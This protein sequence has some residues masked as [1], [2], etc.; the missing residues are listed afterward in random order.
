M[1]ATAKNQGPFVTVVLRRLSLSNKSVCH[2]KAE[3]IALRPIYIALCGAPALLTKHHSNHCSIHASVCRK[4]DLCGS[5]TVEV[6]YYLFTCLLHTTPFR[7]TSESN[8]PNTCFKILAG[9]EYHTS[10]SEH[11]WKHMYCEQYCL[12][13]KRVMRLRVCEE[14]SYEFPFLHVGAVAADAGI[15]RTSILII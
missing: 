14:S 8:V 7:S 6:A 9:S 1:R 5:S 13:R 15:Q 10:S 4:R 2:R 11:G 12:T 3:N